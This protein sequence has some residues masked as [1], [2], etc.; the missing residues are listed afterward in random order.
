MD[1]LDALIRT[2]TEAPEAI[3][4]E[5]MAIVRETTEGAASEM[6]HRYTVQ[7]GTLQRRVRTSYPS[8]RIL[9]GIAQSTAPHAHLYEFGTR[10]RRTASGAN[11]GVMPAASPAVVVPIAQRWRARMYAR[12]A[13]ML[14]D[15]GFV[16]E[17][18]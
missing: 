4:E 7:T 16:V 12:L 5:G 14:R 17:G 15:R 9:V 13:A 2:L 18:A 6:A 1:G 11:R 10:A 8:S 3:R